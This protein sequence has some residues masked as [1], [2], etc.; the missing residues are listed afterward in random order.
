[1]TIELTPV[2]LLAGLG[3][4]VIVVFAWRA[5]LH[6]AR[7]A[8]DA[9]RSSARLM[10]LTGRVVFTAGVIAVAQWIVMTHPTSDTLRW[11][12]LGLPALCA[13]YALTRALTVTTLDVPRNRGGRR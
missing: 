12:V 7:K 5:S 3:V 2:Q 9:A 8:A 6:S 4:L 13:G 11:V 10:S 1:M